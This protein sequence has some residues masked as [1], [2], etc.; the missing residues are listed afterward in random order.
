MFVQMY[1]LAEYVYRLT[2][3]KDDPVLISELWLSVIV[4]FQFVFLGLLLELGT[5]N[6]I[7]YAG[8]FV[9]IG[10]QILNYYLFS[11]K[12]K[13]LVVLE[14]YKDRSPG[15]TWAIIAMAITIAAPFLMIF[16][17]KDT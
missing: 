16:A 13:Y 4:S 10:M 11:Y 9:C 6:A 12:K 8:G 2:K 17:N 3:K 14:N 1:N 5:G 7:A 15:F